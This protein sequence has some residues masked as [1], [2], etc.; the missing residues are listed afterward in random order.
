MNCG[1][2]VLGV[3]EERAELGDALAEVEEEGVGSREGA[4]GGLATL[5]LASV[6]VGV[7]VVEGGVQGQLPSC[8]RLRGRGSPGPYERRQHPPDV[9]DEALHD[10]LLLLLDAHHD[11]QLVDDVLDLLEQLALGVDVQQVVLRRVVGRDVSLAFVVAPGEV[12]VDEELVER[13]GLLICQISNGG[14]EELDEVGLAAVRL[15]PVEEDS[16]SLVDDD[17]SQVVGRRD[18]A[19]AHVLES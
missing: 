19:L 3:L 18:L 2:G 7:V 8:G 17:Q 10:G 5:V 16:R 13:G 6:G 9:L 12:R 1:S 15:G 11:V 4:L 14:V